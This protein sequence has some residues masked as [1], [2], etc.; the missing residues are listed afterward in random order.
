MG[1][2]YDGFFIFLFGACFSILRFCNG[3]PSCLLLFDY[4]PLHWDGSRLKDFAS[5]AVHRLDPS[6]VGNDKSI[7]SP[8]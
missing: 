1:F 6:W 8:D 3:F 2:M 7:C 5:I 4:T